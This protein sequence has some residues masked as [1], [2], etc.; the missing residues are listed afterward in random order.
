M[1]EEAFLTVGK[2]A[3]E[4]LSIKLICCVM[5][6]PSLLCPSYSVAQ[7]Q[8]TSEFEFCGL[9]AAK[10]ASK[11]LGLSLSED[12]FP[13]LR[14]LKIASLFDLRCAFEDL[15]LR[16][17]SYSVL[18]S[19]W[20][21]VRWLKKILR[22][23]W[24]EVIVLVRSRGDDSGASGDRSEQ[25]GHYYLANSFDGTV[26]E[27]LEPFTRQTEELKFSEIADQSGN[28]IFLHV[29]HPFSF[30]LVAPTSIEELIVF[31]PVLLLAAWTFFRCKTQGALEG[32]QHLFGG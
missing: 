11:R 20:V 8:T 18:D 29:Y 9:E 21:R 1:A 23:R 3:I 4:F 22:S 5:S 7:Q 17:D 13:E 2:R 26:M 19:D 10:T 30:S 16:V 12:C 15:G 6:M 31:S 27:L 14:R 32:T 25:V 28:L 24:G